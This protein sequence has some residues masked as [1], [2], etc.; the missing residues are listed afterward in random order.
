[1]KKAFFIAMGMIF[2]V[3]GSGWGINN[4]DLLLLRAA[5]ISDETLQVIIKE[6]VIETCAFSVQE[7]IDLKL[8]GG[9]SDKTIRLMV[10][11]GSFI[12]NRSPV[13][14]G[15][16]IQAFNFITLKDILELK[17]AGL[18]DEIVQAII[19]SGSGSISQQDRDKAWN[20]LKHIGIVIDTRKKQ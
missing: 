17:Q 16:D 14:Y 11:E 8:K 19:I 9:V 10:N 6:K 3:A 20:M 7:L 12:K 18:S 2:W 15:Q 13:V 5:G 4:N 1:M